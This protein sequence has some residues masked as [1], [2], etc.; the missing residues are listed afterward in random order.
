MVKTHEVELHSPDFDVLK[1][2]EYIIL[3]AND[4]APEDF[5][6]FKETI[7]SKEI[8]VSTGLFQMTQ[9]NEVV[10]SAGLKDGYVLLIVK[11]VV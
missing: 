10:K 7:A 3:E 5:I 11:K 9:V 4:Y 6:L 8:E 2:T 1:T